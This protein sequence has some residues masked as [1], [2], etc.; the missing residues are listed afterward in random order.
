MSHIP[1]P[2]KTPIGQF[3]KQVD[4]FKTKIIAILN[5]L[6]RLEEITEL[7]K[8]NDK[9]LLAKKANIRLPINL[10]YE[11]GIQIY[12]KQIL[13]RDELFFIKESRNLEN[14]GELQTTYE[15][16]ENDVLFIKQIRAIWFDLNDN[17][18]KNIWSYV[19]VICMLAEKIN[20]GS[21]LATE[22]ARLKQEGLL[23]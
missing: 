9:L 11:Y 18:K 3:Y 1:A 14:N 21:V 2:K 4:D 8:Y 23:K 7:Q 5:K 16:D 17:V 19:Q 15:I 13:L 22:R 6:G 10:L 12:A 20:G